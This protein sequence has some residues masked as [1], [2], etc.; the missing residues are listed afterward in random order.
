MIYYIADTHFRDQAIFD[1]CKRPF[2]TLKEMEEK[3][4][5]SW[6]YKVKDDDLVYVLGDIAKDDDRTSIDIFSTI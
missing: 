5:N 2:K 4:I 1:K 6:N 3:L